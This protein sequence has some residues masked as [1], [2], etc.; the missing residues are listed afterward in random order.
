MTRRRS[1]LKGRAVSSTFFSWPHAVASSEAYR[2]L[3]AQAVKLLNDVCFQ[4][5]GA[6]NGDLAV[7]WSLMQ[8]RGWK[9]RDT[10]RKALVELLEHGL[11]ELTRQGGRHKC[12]L[13]AVTWLPIDECDGK[14][15]VRPTTVASGQWRKWPG[16]KKSF[17]KQI[18]GTQTVSQRPAQRVNQ[19]VS[20]TILTRGACQSEC[21]SR[22]D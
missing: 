13:Y 16:N 11:L 22:V 18:G 10:L 7:T 1:K 5:R 9:S 17:E 21:I 19:Q 15:D 8:Q 12:S 4:F 14:L 2:T 6:N 3:S 20:P